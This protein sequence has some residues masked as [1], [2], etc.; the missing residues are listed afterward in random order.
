M[1]A[2]PTI[3]LA[4]LSF[5]LVAAAAHAKHASHRCE[6]AAANGTGITEKIA[7]FQVYEGLLQATDMALWAEWIAN[8]KTPGHT[9]KPVKYV[10]HAGSG[11]GIFCRGTTT[12]C[13][14]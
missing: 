14:R 9:I 2:I 7:K 3:I 12:I 8:G 5:G 10:C 1:R 4:G 6:N 11:L 13:K